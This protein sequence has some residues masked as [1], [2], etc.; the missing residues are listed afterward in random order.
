MQKR[1]VDELEKEFLGG[2]EEEEKENRPKGLKFLDN[3]VE[4]REGALKNEAAKLLKRLK[5][6]KNLE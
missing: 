5:G 2:N 4:K 6:S 3:F 1:M